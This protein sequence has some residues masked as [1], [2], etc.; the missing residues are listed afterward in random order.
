V[1]Q[2][3]ARIGYTGPVTAEILPVPD[4]STAMQ[5]AG[6]FLASLSTSK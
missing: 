4:D 1:L 6:S 2:T 3:L 5:Q